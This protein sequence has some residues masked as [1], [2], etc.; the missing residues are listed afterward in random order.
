[1]LED[2]ISPTFELEARWTCVGMP[3]ASSSLLLRNEGMHGD[4]GAQRERRREAVRRSSIA[5]HALLLLKRFR[6]AQLHRQLFPPLSPLLDF[7]AAI[8][9]QAAQP[10]AGQRR[11]SRFELSVTERDGCVV[12][13]LKSGIVETQPN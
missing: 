2:A 9:L 10:R 3:L 1:M 6:S 12:S 7:W 11:L 5:Q 13:E 4:S 8:F